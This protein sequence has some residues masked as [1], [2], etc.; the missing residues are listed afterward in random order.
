LDDNLSM[1]VGHGCART[2]PSQAVLVISPMKLL[3]LG[4]WGKPKVPEQALAGVG[5]E[6]D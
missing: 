6:G 2:R 1:V 3:A 5:I 4:D